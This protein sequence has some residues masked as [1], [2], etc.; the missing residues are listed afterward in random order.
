LAAANQEAQRTD[1]QANA[2]QPPMKFFEDLAMG[3][4]LELGSHTFTAEE[5]KSFARSYDP[6]LFHV[7]EEAAARSHFGALCASGWHTAAICMRLFVDAR[8]RQADGM[9]Q[10]GEPVASFGVSPGVRDIRWL[11]PVYVGDTIAYASEIVQLR[12]LATRP[13]WGLLSAHSTGTNQHGDLVYSVIGAVFV[14]R[15][16]A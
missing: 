13:G 9:R 11:K 16:Q 3:D 1:E 12:A 15:R 5:I 14:E 10:R 4:R 8:R 6:Q 2:G 7:D